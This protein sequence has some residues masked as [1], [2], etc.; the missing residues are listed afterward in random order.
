MDKQFP[1]VSVIVPVYNT[2]ELLRAC[3]DSIS[4]QTLK[5]LEIIL[6]DDGSDD[7][8]TLEILEGSLSG[9]SRI[10]LIRKTNG[11]QSSARNAGLEDARGL[12]VAFV[13]HD[14][15]L[16]G[17]MYETLFKAAEIENADV[18]ECRYETLG[19]SRL[20]KLDLSRRPGIKFQRVNIEVDKD[21]LVDQVQVW[22]KIYRADFLRSNDIRF[23]DLLWEEDVL[24][25]FKAMI[26]ARSIL[27]VDAP[28]YFHVKHRENATRKLDRKIFDAFKAH[29][30]L[31]R[32]ME[33]KKC[34]EKFEKQYMGRVLK[35]ILV[36]LKTV[37]EQWEKEFFMEAHLRIR[38]IPLTR[39]QGYYSGSKKK[40]LEFVQKG[41]FEGYRRYRTFREKRKSLLG[42]LFQ[43]RWKQNEKTLVLMGFKWSK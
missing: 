10:R 34:L 33:E 13:D 38:D 31:R 25:S 39:Y 18:A 9:D 24:F 3:L 4:R 15:V 37:H 7:P 23:D 22:R 35:D 1:S 8:L 27:F 32:F 20:G 19:E 12:Y 16:N 5:D 21:Y 11:G 40:L 43:I 30:L 42:N 14:D 41:D 36:N 6:V 26:C 17:F 29:D 2:G 28:L